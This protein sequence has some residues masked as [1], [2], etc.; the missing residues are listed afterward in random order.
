[1]TCGPIFIEMGNL[2]FSRTQKSLQKGQKCDMPQLL[3]RG[4]ERNLK[5]NAFPVHESWADVGQLSKYEQLNGESLL[6][7]HHDLI[8]QRTRYDHPGAFH[9]AFQTR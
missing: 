5:I 6:H 7:I 4:L 2:M 9:Y 8:I 3:K 1:M